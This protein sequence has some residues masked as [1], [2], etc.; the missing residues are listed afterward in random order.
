MIQVKIVK[1]DR[2]SHGTLEEQINAVLKDIQSKDIFNQIFDIRTINEEKVIIT[3]DD[4]QL[5]IDD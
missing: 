2:K 1:Y 5:M 4:K 3:Y